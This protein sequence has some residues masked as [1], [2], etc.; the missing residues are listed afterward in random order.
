M[1]KYLI[2]ILGTVILMGLG[3]YLIN[4]FGKARYKEGYSKSQSEYAI[5]AAAAGNEALRNPGSRKSCSYPDLCRFELKGFT[6]PGLVNTYFTF[7][8]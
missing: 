1:N 3:A 7:F 5:A 2:I 4:S 8:S 6:L